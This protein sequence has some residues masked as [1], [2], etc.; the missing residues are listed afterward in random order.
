MISSEFIIN[1]IVI[2]VITIVFGYLLGLAVSQVVDRRLSEISINLPKITIPPQNIHVDLGT[3]Q[4]Q[5]KPTTY[6]HF[7]TDENEIDLINPE[8]TKQY[9]KPPVTP[10]KVMTQTEPVVQNRPIGQTSQVIQN[11]LVQKSPTVQTRPINQSKSQIQVQPSDQ[12]QVKPML[13]CNTDRDCNVVYGHGLNRCLS[14]HQCYCNRGSGQFCHYG[15][16]YYKDPKDMTDQQVRKF[17]LRA[18]I[19]KM[20]LQD[21]INWLFLFEDEQDLLPQRHFANLQ[22]LLKGLTLTQNDIPRDQVPP[23]MT[24]Q[25]YYH[26]MY[27]LDEQLNPRDPNTA[28]IQIPANYMEYSE[29]E[30]PKNLKHLDDSDHLLDLHKYE[31]REVILKTRPKI[32]HDWNN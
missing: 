13:G 21:Y 23:P 9:Q 20:T 28:G 4:S 11:P 6:E 19:Y 10:I 32:E 1:L 27:T 14:N 5:I 24:A 29:F 3:N 8:L 30:K 15:P 16:T 2:C 22:K 26:Q 25:E 12:A 17:K 7:T 18:K 31:N